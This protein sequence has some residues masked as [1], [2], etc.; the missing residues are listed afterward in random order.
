[1][2]TQLYAA[3][4]E[5]TVHG[6][7]ERRLRL[8]IQHISQFPSD[9]QLRRLVV[10]VMAGEGLVQ[11]TRPV[12][13]RIVEIDRARGRIPGLVANAR[14]AEELGLPSEDAWLALASLVA[15]RADAPQGQSETDR[16]H[17]EPSPEQPTLERAAL[18]ALAA[19][20]AARPCENLQEQPVAYVPLLS[21]LSDSHAMQL[22]HA[23]RLTTAPANSPVLSSEGM[24]AWLVMGA[25][26]DTDRAAH[27]LPEGT[28]LTR[29]TPHTS[30][31]CWLLTADDTAWEQLCTQPE[32]ATALQNSLLSAQAAAIIGRS[33]FSYA[34]GP[35]ALT[36]FLAHALAFAAPAGAIR[37]AGEPSGGIGMVV[38]GSLNMA[39]RHDEKSAVIVTLHAGD[40]FGAESGSHADVALLE[41]VNP[42]PVRWIW[43]PEESTGPWLAE[44]PAALHFLSAQA[45]ARAAT[46]RRLQ[47][48]VPEVAVSA[49]EFDDSA[50]T[51]VQGAGS[52]ALESLADTP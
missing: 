25:F 31:P 52:P 35:A 49:T 24:A 2:H 30:T 44:H 47:N 48:P 46:L 39:L 18:L 36:Q 12:L 33:A 13:R 51:S 8:L 1:M 43:V 20:V 4:E 9:C 6:T 45:A 16:P 7:I 50:Q 29:H 3:I 15:R 37:P 10:R 38:S 19:E 14:L 22:L 23:L 17:V 34:V 32:I 27:W 28:L 26:A 40:T 5:S 21:H 41:L 11:Q 42:E